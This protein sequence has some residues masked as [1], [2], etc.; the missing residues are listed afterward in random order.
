MNKHLGNYL[1]IGLPKP[2]YLQGY[3]CADTC[4]D[5][6]FGFQTLRSGPETIT[7]LLLDLVNVKLLERTYVSSVLHKNHSDCVFAFMFACCIR[8][9]GSGKRSDK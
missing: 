7:V 9:N 8:R 5:V 2:S 6:M 1:H 4:R 3:L